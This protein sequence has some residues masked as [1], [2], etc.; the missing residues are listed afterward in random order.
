ML[1]ISSSAQDED[2]ICMYLSTVNL[3]SH[4][5]HY[6]FILFPSDDRRLSY[7]K[8]PVLLKQLS[9][10][11]TSKISVPVLGRLSWGESFLSPV[12][13]SWRAGTSSIWYFWAYCLPK[14]GIGDRG[15]SR[16]DHSSVSLSYVFIT[17]L[18]SLQ[19]AN[20][21]YWVLF[22]SVVSSIFVIVWEWNLFVAH[23]GTFIQFTD[24]SGRS[25]Q[26]YK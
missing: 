13:W 23:Y 10:Q 9:G 19:R 26:Y 21:Q 2:Y 18:Q 8:C 4:H 7:S 25:A 16:K 22:G 1:E 24:S 15:P 20:E 11:D 3:I 14:Y 6:L 5:T 12:V 17:Y